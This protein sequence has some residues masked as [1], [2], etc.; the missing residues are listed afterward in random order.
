MGAAYRY[1]VTRYSPTGPV[2][3][4]HATLTT[5]TGAVQERMT[6]AVA[7]GR[8]VFVGDESAPLPASLSRARRIDALNAW[9]SAATFDYEAETPL[10]GI[11]HIWVG[12]IYEGA[13]GDLVISNVGPDRRR[14]SQSTPR[15]ILGVVMGGRY[16]SVAELTRGRSAA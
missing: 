1:Y 15:Q 9:I 10:D 16:F 4:L 3:F 8:V 14:G 6:V 2:V 12:Q 13:P 5:S 11:R 7:N